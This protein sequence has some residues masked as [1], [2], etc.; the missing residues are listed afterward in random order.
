MK[1]AFPT[2]KRMPSTPKSSGRKH[3][4]LNRGK[5]HQKFKTYFQR[6]SASKRNNRLQGLRSFKT[7]DDQ[8][9]SKPSKNMFQPLFCTPRP[10]GEPKKKVRVVSKTLPD[11]VPSLVKNVVKILSGK[12]YKIKS[13]DFVMVSTL[14]LT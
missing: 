8:H 12:S 14:S 10:L 1:S 11:P 13:F 4:T 2:P 5:S 9:L 6:H 7:S 3:E